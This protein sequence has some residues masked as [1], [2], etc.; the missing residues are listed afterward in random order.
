MFE[1]EKHVCVQSQIALHHIVEMLL[2]VEHAF[3]SIN[4]FNIRHR[5]QWSWSIDGNV[6]VCGHPAFSP[7]FCETSSTMIACLIVEGPLVLDAIIRMADKNYH[8]SDQECLQ[9]KSKS[10]LIKLIKH[11]QKTQWI[12]KLDY[13]T[14]EAEKAL[15]EAFVQFNFHDKLSNVFQALPG[16]RS[17]ISNRPALGQVNIF[18]KIEPVVLESI[19]VALQVWRTKSFDLLVQLLDVFKE[20]LF[21]S[22]LDQQEYILEQVTHFCIE[23]MRHFTDTI[24]AITGFNPEIRFDITGRIISRLASDHVPLQSIQLSS[25]QE[26]LAW[27]TACLEMAIIAHLERFGADLQRK[28]QSYMQY[29]FWHKLMHSFKASLIT[30]VLACDKNV[31]L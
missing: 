8:I 21:L 12:A 28:L 30:V 27:K 1:C 15:K 19:K 31:K 17:I 18:G 5:D 26:K 14:V 11:H 20:A 25:L 4:T 9:M 3:A 6:F 7:L 2:G 10:E 22:K 24:F 13:W 16:K 29:F 23:P